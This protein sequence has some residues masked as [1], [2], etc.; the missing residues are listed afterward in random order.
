MSQIFIYEEERLIYD[1]EF[2]IS[3]PHQWLHNLYC[4]INLIHNLCIKYN[5]KY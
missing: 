4:L 2:G 1:W 3:Q 5:T